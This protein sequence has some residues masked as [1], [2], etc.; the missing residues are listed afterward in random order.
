MNDHKKITKTELQYEIQENTLDTIDLI[1]II[2]FSK[3]GKM[4]K[5]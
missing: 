3:S 2:K 5:R 4:E 1:D